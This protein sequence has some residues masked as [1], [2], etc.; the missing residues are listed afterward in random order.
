M[1]VS[2]SALPEILP[3]PAK[4]KKSRW[5]LIIPGVLWVISYGLGRF[6]PLRQVLGEAWFLLLTVILPLF[7]GL[8]L[9]GIRLW[10]YENRRDY[11]QQWNET[12]R[13]TEEKLV[14][15]GQKS[16]GVLSLA[17]HTA[18]ANNKLADV[19][20]QGGKALAPVY[21]AQN[22]RVEYYSQLQP[23][24]VTKSLDEYRQRLGL[25][26]GQVLSSLTNEYL[27]QPCRLRIRHDGSLADSQ[28]L[29]ILHPLL[30]KEQIP[31]NGVIFDEDADGLLWIDKWLDSDTTPPLTLSIEIQFHVSPLPFIAESVSAI[32]FAKNSWCDQQGVTPLADVHRP[33][34]LSARS[35]ALE[36][37]LLFGKV[38]P[39]A[40]LFLWQSPSDQEPLVGVLSEL[41]SHGINVTAHQHAIGQSLGVPGV[42]VGSLALV[43]AVEHLRSS[44]QKQLILLQ[45]HA[46]QGCVVRAHREQDK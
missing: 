19:L 28:V 4:P 1:P 9:Y 44:R 18:A 22:E 35:G 14:R 7:I 5:L 36:D 41:D 32:L 26:L 25:H 45:D 2:F 10:I 46:F 16:I 17:Y 3:E 15:Q 21:H 34:E 42:A 38:T 20:L 39:P 31:V 27:N 33:V 23:A 13:V 12:R 40:S 30:Q 8:I 37:L 11:V 24:P 6:F 29:E 43:C